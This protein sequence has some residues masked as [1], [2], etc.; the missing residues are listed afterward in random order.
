FSVS[1]TSLS[2]PL[3]G[4]QHGVVDARKVELPRGE[5]LADLGDRGAENPALLRRGRGTETVARRLRLGGQPGLAA[6]FRKQ[7]R[8]PVSGEDDVREHVTHGGGHRGASSRVERRHAAPQKR[9]REG[10]VT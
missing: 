4:T 8:V 6:L 9:P 7:P 2:Y 10:H 1:M 5:P 3:Y